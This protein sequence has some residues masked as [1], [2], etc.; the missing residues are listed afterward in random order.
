VSATNTLGAH[1]SERHRIFSFP[2]IREANWV[3]IDLMRPSY[4]DNNRGKGF[5]AAYARFR[6]SGNWIVVRVEDGV[7]VWRRLL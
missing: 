7:I 1:L 6:R 4:L 2:V 5:P 3:A